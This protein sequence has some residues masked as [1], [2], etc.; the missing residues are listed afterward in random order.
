MMFF[1]NRRGKKGRAARRRVGGVLA[2]PIALWTAGIVESLRE[3][4]QLSGSSMHR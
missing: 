3:Y 1:L 2:R 4:S